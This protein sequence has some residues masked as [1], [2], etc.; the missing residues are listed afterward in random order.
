M[1]RTEFT[2]HHYAGD[3]TYTSVGFVDKN[4]DLLS[5]DL[6]AVL[7]DSS[8]GL[9]QSL[10][11]DTQQPV[12]A[13][14]S[15]SARRSRRGSAIVSDTVT[16]KFKTQLG[17]LMAQ[18]SKTSVQ[19]VRCIK[20]N[21]LKSTT[22]MNN[23]MVVEQLR[24]AG[25]IEAIRISRAGYPNRMLHSEFVPRFKLLNPE[26]Q[27]QGDGKKQCATLG[28]IVLADKA[29]AYQIGHTKIYFKA[30]VLEKLE[31]RRGQIVLGQIIKI[32]KMMRGASIRRNFVKKRKAAVVISA[33]IR[34]LLMRMKYLRTRR[35]VI[36]I[37][38]R[39]R[40]KIAV[41]KTILLRRMKAATRIQA[42]A[43][44][45]PYDGMISGI[46]RKVIIIQTLQRTKAARAK[47][48]VDL[49][50]AKEE[51]KLENR[52]KALQDQLLQDQ[53]RHQSELEAAKAAAAAGAPISAGDITLEQRSS[54]HSVEDD[55]NE[56]MNKSREMIDHLREQVT[57]LRKENDELKGKVATL[58]SDQVSM[59]NST[60]ANSGASFTALSNE[61]QKRLKANRELMDENKLLHRT[62]KQK[63]EELDYMREIKLSLT[64]NVVK[65]QEIM[66]VMVDSAKRHHASP[67]LIEEMEE[68]SSK[69]IGAMAGMDELD[70][71]VE[72]SR[73]ARDR[74]RKSS[75]FGVMQGGLK[76]A[77][78]FDK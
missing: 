55:T 17:S 10:F 69:E 30:G 4:K 76:N 46:R 39:C 6:V 1:S 57:K 45:K 15:S 47:Y 7:R 49:A 68:L 28:G 29:E 48:V 51:A 50:A 33:F 5:D 11:V 77:F 71:R 66:G 72:R 9:V 44:R 36:I 8:D 21:R 19:Y 32:Q 59:Q 73:Q 58:R 26:A 67:E 34:R 35:D 22:V 42:V 78:N 70:D 16:T 61:L 54:S 74:P 52:L 24:C 53:L 14:S 23:L 62:V 75:F 31:E 13:K 25:V 27:L 65:L 38:C 40:L 43:R 63:T 41:T 37:Q 3:V 2:L 60:A 20:P 64:L 18:I 56:L 12:A